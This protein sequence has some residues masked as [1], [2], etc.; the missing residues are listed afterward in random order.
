M[1]IYVVGSSKNRFLPLNDIREKFL[2]D[3]KHDDLNIDFMNPWYCEL[4]GLFYLWQHVNEDVVGLEHYR[5]YHLNSKNEIMSKDEIEEALKDH[6]IICT[7]E[8]DEGETLEQRFRFMRNELQYLKDAIKE[9]H[10]EQYSRLNEFLQQ[11][12]HWQFN[13]FICKKELLNEY[14]EWLFPILFA[15]TA[16]YRTKLTK[17]S[18]GYL[19]EIILFTFYFT[20]INKK[21]IYQSTYRLQRL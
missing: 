1:K 6:D 3:E 14:C 20:V 19:A 16:K 21:K 13:M 5:R 17:R 4:T 7:K 12:W 18:I 11:R 9:L 15:I 8:P 10:P 2:I